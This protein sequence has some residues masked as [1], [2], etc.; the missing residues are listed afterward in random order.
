MR[1]ASGPAQSTLTHS[2]V[3]PWNAL[4]VLPLDKIPVVPPVTVVKI[5][6]PINVRF[7][8]RVPHNITH[9]LYPTTPRH[10]A[11]PLPPLSCSCDLLIS[12][13]IEYS[14]LWTTV[15]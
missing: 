13:T 4:K 5:V 7:F 10:D 11:L 1:G 9:T 14:Y 15:D 3:R 6:P 8:M 2:K 12:C